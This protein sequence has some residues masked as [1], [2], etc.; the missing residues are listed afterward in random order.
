MLRVLLAGHRVVY[1][2]TAIVRHAQERG[3]ASVERRVYGYGV[4]LT[5]CIAKA[6]VT[7][8]S[9]LRHLLPKLPYGV[10]YAVSPGSPKNRDKQQDFPPRWTRLE[11]RGMLMGPALYG[12]GRVKHSLGSRRGSGASRSG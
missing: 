7:H 12:L 2:P 3:F 8:P 5:A 6:V 4:G 9:L 10:A 11:L 1:E